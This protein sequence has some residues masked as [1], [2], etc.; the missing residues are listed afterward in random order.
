MFFRK[1]LR[2]GDYPSRIRPRRTRSA[3]VSGNRRRAFEHLEDRRVMAVAFASVLTGG[4]TI[5]D[6]N[7]GDVI[8]DLAVDSAG[9]T[10][11]VGKFAGTVDFDPGAGT[12]EL[13]SSPATARN[14]YVAK[15]DASNN[16]LWARAFGGDTSGA[17]GLSG[18]V[19]IDS[20]GNV[21][22]AGTF[23]GTAEFGS[24]SLISSG[25]TDA[26]LT[27]LDSSGNFL[28]AKQFGGVNADFGRGIDVD[29]TGNAILAATSFTTSSQS[30]GAPSDLLI[31]KIAPNGTTTWSTAIG[32]SSSIPTRGNMNPTGYAFAGNIT[33]DGAGAV[34]VA[35]G[36]GGTVDFDVSSGTTAITGV[37]FVTKLNAGGSLVWARAFT[38]PNGSYGSLG[39]AD[40]VVDAAGN[41]YSTGSYSGTIDFH[42]G[43]LK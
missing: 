34:Y 1:E 19:A 18:E 7:V 15:Y 22:V 39:P 9:N 16:L 36:M 14:N 5:A 32:S 17:G 10:I 31:A 12:Y 40:I 21:F 26:F 6:T 13:T 24:A 33:V 42:P 29:G 43:T 41:I 27:K 3:N 28:W 2:R 38:P 4:S 30:R 20:V 8:S 23:A 37:G 25:P 35:G 11:V